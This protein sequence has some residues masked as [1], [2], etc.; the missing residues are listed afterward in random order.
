MVI[1][2]TVVRPD[3]SSRKRKA[4]ALVTS[5]RGATAVEVASGTEVGVGAESHP[6]VPT[7]KVNPANKPN[8]IRNAIFIFPP[9]M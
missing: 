8:S 3:Q 6:N 1:G 9:L 2:E 5:L 7:S 4:V